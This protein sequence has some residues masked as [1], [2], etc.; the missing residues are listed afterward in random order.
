MSI[1]TQQG[2]GARTGESSFLVRLLAAFGIRFV[3]DQ[4]SDSGR[5]RS[6][7]RRSRQSVPL[8]EL[9]EY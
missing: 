2:I 3:D 6:T 1:E 7:I 8:W 5:D 9:D 4:P